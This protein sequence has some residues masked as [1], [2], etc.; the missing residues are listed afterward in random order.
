MLVLLCK[1]PVVVQPTHKTAREEEVQARHNVSIKWANIN[2]GVL[3][4]NFILTAVHT[5]PVNQLPSSSL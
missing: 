4:V 1:L 5:Q 2:A 3:N